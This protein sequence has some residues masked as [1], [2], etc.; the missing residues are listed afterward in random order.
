MIGG[1]AR[2][3]IT[4]RRKARDAVTLRML[5]VEWW[6]GCS[7]WAR[8]TMVALLMLGCSMALGLALDTYRGSLPRAAQVGCR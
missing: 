5:V 3:P 8:R 7:L 4:E 6:R 1:R 2:R